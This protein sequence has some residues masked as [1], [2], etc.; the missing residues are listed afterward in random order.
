LISLRLIVVVIVTMT[1]LVI[2]RP[3]RSRV[4]FLIALALLGFLGV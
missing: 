1:E 4:D 3:E 2:P